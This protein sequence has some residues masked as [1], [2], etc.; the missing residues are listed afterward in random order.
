MQRWPET[1]RLLGLLVNSSGAAHARNARRLVQAARKQDRRLSA[2]LLAA[3]LAHTPEAPAGARRRAHADGAQ[4]ERAGPRAAARTS[5]RAGAAAAAGAAAR[6]AAAMPRRRRGRRQATAGEGAPRRR[7]ETDRA[8]SRTRP[9]RSTT[10]DAP[11]RRSPSDR[12]AP[13]A[14]AQRSRCTSPASSSTRPCV[15][16][17]QQR[18]GVV[19]PGRRAAAARP[20]APARRG[21]RRGRARP[22]APRRA[23]AASQ[24]SRRRQQ[25]AEHLLQVGVAALQR[26]RRSALRS[27]AG[28]SLV[29]RSARCPAPPSPPAAAPPRG[30]PRPC[31]RSIQTSLGH[32]IA[33]SAA[34]A[35]R[36]PP[37]PR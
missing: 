33:A 24:R 7:E 23:G 28:N 22:P 31:G 34:A 11:E 9:A 37:R 4:A 10:P 30:C 2:A 16:V 8:R 27:S 36:R 29:P 32:L 20:S 12:A 21:A 17:D 26:Q 18:A 19:D 35:P 3:A 15:G 6:R 13:S 5:R 1:K 14:R 25:R